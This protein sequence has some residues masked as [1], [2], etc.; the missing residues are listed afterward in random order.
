M[1]YDKLIMKD[2]QNQKIAWTEFYQQKIGKKPIYPTEWVIRTLAG[3]NYPNLKLDKNAYKNA[4]IL[5]L[6]CGDGRNLPLLL[7]LEFDVH[8]TEISEDILD[9]LIKFAEETNW[10]IDFQKGTN[11]NLPYSD[12][13]FDYILSCS[14]FYYMEKEIKWEQIMEEIC[15][16]LRP[17]G[18]FIAN[19]PDQYNS[20]LQNGVELEDGSMLIQNDPFNL[21]NG[22][23]FMIARNKEEVNQLLSPWF[24]NV[25]V[26][27]YKDDFYG[28]VVSG[29]IFVAQKK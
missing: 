4:K 19:I 9:N 15:R 13:Y 2:N 18:F 29:Y 17:N 24:Q 5:D 25:T 6:G 22:I 27:H 23:R 1:I 28:L 21:R 16:V 10:K 20:V 11:T 14:S 7:N 26:G 8:A 3:G 12:N